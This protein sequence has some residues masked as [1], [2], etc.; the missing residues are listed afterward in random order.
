MVLKLHNP[1]PKS[2]FLTGLYLSP[3]AEIKTGVAAIGGGTLAADAVYSV[4]NMVAAPAFLI[5][6]TP[7]FVFLVAVDNISDFMVNRAMKNGEVKVKSHR[8]PKIDF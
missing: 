7:V 6:V 1:R 2:K 3:L 4:F 8:R 5:V